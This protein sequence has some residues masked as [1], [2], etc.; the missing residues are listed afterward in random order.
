MRGIDLIFDL[1]HRI[2]IFGSDGL[3]SSINFVR[4]KNRAVRIELNATETVESNT[5]IIMQKCYSFSRWSTMDST[6]WNIDVPQLPLSFT[7]TKFLTKNI[8]RKRCTRTRTLNKKIKIGRKR[9]YSQNAHVT[10]QRYCTLYKHL[11][12]HVRAAD[13]C[14]CGSKNKNPEQKMR[15]RVEI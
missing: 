3:I 15:I 13:E 1:K 14:E 4:K 5:T 6:T 11:C 9:M 7:H 10:T 2:I 12:D 8:V